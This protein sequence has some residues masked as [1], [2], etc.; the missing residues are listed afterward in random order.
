MSDAG[1]SE[2]K[3]LIEKHVAAQG[4]MTL[5]GAT[6]DSITPGACSISLAKRPEVLQQY[7]MFHGGATAFLVDNATTM[8][9]ATVM[10]ADQ[11]AL[12]AEFKLNFLSPAVGETLVC[13]ARVIKPGRTLT[14]VAADVFG[15][16]HGREKHTATALATIAMV[17]GASLPPVK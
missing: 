7:G 1:F 13:R 14:I 2:R 10:G 8:A 5:V 12:T 4:F 9:A 15:I 16:S 17:D 3:A 6:I 11:L